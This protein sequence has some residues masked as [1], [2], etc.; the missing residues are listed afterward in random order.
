MDKVCSVKEA[1]YAQIMVIL[2]NIYFDCCRCNINLCRIRE[3]DYSGS[4]SHY[5]LLPGT[6]AITYGYRRVGGNG[7]YS[8]FLLSCKREGKVADA[9]ISISIGL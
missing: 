5:V 3:G 8:I 1:L 9:G 6:L 4:Q 2:F 7:G